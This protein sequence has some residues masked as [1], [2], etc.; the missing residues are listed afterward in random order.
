MVPFDFLG[1]GGVEDLEKIIPASLEEKNKY[2]AERVP[3]SFP[4]FL[5]SFDQNPGNEV[6]REREC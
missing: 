5:I 2:D 1:G 6:E 3:T 4:G